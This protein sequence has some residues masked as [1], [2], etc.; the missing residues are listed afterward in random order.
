MVLGLEVGEVALL[1]PVDQVAQEVE[2]MLPDH[3]ID[4]MVI[5]TV[6]LIEG[7]IE[8]LIGG[9]GGLLVI[10]AGDG[11]GDGTIGDGMV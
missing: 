8:V 6:V 5:D 11:G 7:H 2:A 9:L 10:I 4:L 1:D 3:Y